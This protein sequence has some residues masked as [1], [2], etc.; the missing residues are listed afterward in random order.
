[1]KFFLKNGEKIQKGLSLLEED[2]GITQTTEAEADVIVTLQEKE[3]DGLSVSLKGHELSITFGGGISRCFRGLC[4]GVEWLKQGK[5]EDTLIENPVFERNGGMLDVSR[6]AVMRVE[7]VKVMLRKIALMGLNTFMLYTEDTYEIEGRPYFGHLRGRYS[8][9]ELKELDAYASA[10]G[11]ELIPCIQVL[12]HM[13]RYLRWAAASPV[14]DTINEMLV[15]EE[16][17]YELIGD[18]FSTVKECFT[19]KRVHI[20]MDETHHLGRGSYLD[21]NG[22]RPL[23]DIY[24]EHL[25]RVVAMTKEY[26][27]EPMMWSDVFFKR[28]GFVDYDVRVE[29]TQ[30]VIN[31]MPKEATPVFWDYYHSDEDFYAINLEK[32]KKL[33]DKTIFAGGVWCWAGFT[34]YNSKTICHSVPALEAC[35]KSGT[36]EVLATIWHNG[37]ESFL[38]TALPGL[39]LYAEY[40]YKG[41]YCEEDVA[42]CVKRT[43]QAEYEDFQIMNQVDMLH[44]HPDQYPMIRGALYNDPLQGLLDCNFQGF[45]SHGYYKE[46]LQKLEGRGSG[47]FA[48]AFDV[49]RTLTSVLTQKCD[50][51][52]R[53]KNAYDQKNE[54][55]LKELKKECELLIERMKQLRKTHKSA[56]MY[57]NKAFGWKSFDIR[58]GTML[59][60][61]SSVCEFLDEYLA[62]DISCI[63]E[64]EA[65]R[66]WHDGAELEQEKA[67]DTIASIEFMGLYNIDML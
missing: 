10:L 67:I 18:M 61:L 25:N 49:I 26:E 13:T 12:G 21:K 15:G 60:R 19:T 62:G 6:N 27:L 39:A 55:K 56:W 20:G 32:H 38:M 37:A 63:E 30:D 36:K 28:P 3:T 11:I 48:P 35:K 46:L 29:L 57:Y 34:H 53:L 44:Q 8:K 50:F 17:T 40:Q 33:S 65:P 51:G 4:Y 66:L 24:M 64:L 43:C 59:C 22:Y 9:D 41:N 14:R 52:I 54:Q 16:K 58:Y 2:L 47:V 45:D 1:M 42:Y 7:M 5:R 31:R 23:L